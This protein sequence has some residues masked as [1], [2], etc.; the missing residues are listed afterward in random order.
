LDVTD[1]ASPITVFDFW[2]LRLSPVWVVAPFFYNIS[3]RRSFATLTWKS[4]ALG[5]PFVPRNSGLTRTQNSFRTSL[6]VY[7]PQIT[8]HDFSRPSS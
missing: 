2:S 6:R 4:A 1:Y 7:Q 5:R 3:D 8:D